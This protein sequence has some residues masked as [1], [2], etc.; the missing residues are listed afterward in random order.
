MRE[1]PNLQDL[2]VCHASFNVFADLHEDA[3]DRELRRVFSR[4]ALQE[5]LVGLKANIAA[6]GSTWTAG[7]G[8]RKTLIAE[9]DAVVTQR[10]RENGA[11]VLPGLNMDAAA[12]GG[13]TDNPD[14]GRTLNP[15]A[16]EHSVGGSSG[17]SAAAVAAGLLD[18]ALGTDTLGSVRIPASYC[19]VFGLKP[20]CGLV[21]RSGIVALAPS[22]DTVGPITA[23]AVDLWPLLTV[24]AGSDTGDPA[25]R[26]APKGWIATRPEPMIRGV[27]I[28]V[29]NQIETVDCEIGVLSALA[30]V[31]VALADAGAV[32]TDIDMPGWDPGKLRQKAF[33]L[34]EAEGAV[35]YSEELET[36]GV[37]PTSVEALLNFGA[38]MGTTRLVSAY[39]EVAA[40]NAQLDRTFSSVDVL[41]MPTTPQRAFHASQKPPVNQADFTALANA[42]GIPAVSVPVWMSDSPLPASVQLFGPAWSESMLIGL[43][44][45]LEEILRPPQSG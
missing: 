14:F 13:A 19:G 9:S 10:L 4:G 28:G 29:P 31:K 43:A 20:T 7:L 5:R 12:L 42:G 25:S 45:L 26:P 18:M 21:G 34:I 6:E 17:G 22:L 30:N 23:R 41:L 1:L 35:E 8:H 11:L 38:D 44:A 33:L 40:A 27:R 3:M 32:I 37:L 24:I 36:G 2:R 39:Q 16:P 15:H